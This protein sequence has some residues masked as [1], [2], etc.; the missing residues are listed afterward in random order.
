MA[1]PR[2]TW[3]TQ[4]GFVFEAD[5]FRLVVDPYMSDSLAGKVTRLVGFPLALEDLRP[6]AVICTHDHLDHLDPETIA[7]IARHYPRCLFGSPERAHG[8]LRELGI[9][10]PMLL[11]VGHTMTLG[12]LGITPVFARHSDPTAVGLV[13][14]A[15]G[16]RFYLTADTEYDERLFSATTNAPD[17][18]LVCINGR[19]GNMTW[20][21]AAQ[22]AQ[23][24][25]TPVALPM[26]YGLF[27]ENTEDPAPFI[28]A[29]RAAGI[30]SFEMPLGKPFTL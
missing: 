15:D 19:L 11:K 17:A 25:K 8:H 13:I 18:L 7:M 30:S 27:A 26:H 21:E 5:G 23:R 29:C 6:D 9:D 12:P 24:L 16:R 3:I 10:S 20:Q 22:M 2:I 14:G 4:G 1:S 28:A